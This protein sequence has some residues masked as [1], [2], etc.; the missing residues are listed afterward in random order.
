[1]YAPGYYINLI[2]NLLL[3]LANNISL[4]HLE[5]RVSDPGEDDPCPDPT[6]ENKSDPDPTVNKRGFESV[7]AD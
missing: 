7:C 1:M 4:W 2:F 3:S 5:T 6:L